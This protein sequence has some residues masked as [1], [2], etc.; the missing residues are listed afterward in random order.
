MTKTNLAA[1]MTTKG[2]VVAGV[3]RIPGGV[4]VH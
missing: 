1:S 4:R 3:V 2:V